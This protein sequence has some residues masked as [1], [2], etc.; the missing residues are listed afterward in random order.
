ME[1][2]AAP[3]PDVRPLITVAVLLVA[4]GL[5]W[6]MR[7]AFSASLWP[8]SAAALLACGLLL[9]HAILAVAALLAPSRWVAVVTTVLLAGELGVALALPATAAWWVAVM[10]TGLAAAML[11]ARGAMT[12]MAS[13]TRTDRV[14]PVATALVVALAL[15][16]ALVGALGYE[17]V[18]TAGWVLAAASL[19]LAWAYMRAFVAALWAIR[20]VM[21]I[22]VIAALMGAPAAAVLGFVLAGAI[23]TVLAWARQAM[24]AAN[25][26]A[27][28]RVS[29]VPVLPE[30]VPAE[31]LESAGFDAR[32]RPKEKGPQ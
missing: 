9:A 32:G 7:L 3:R 21:P 20:T 4:G 1:P 22:M 2:P 29:P 16:P 10:T 26:L 6:V 19:I 31:L 24:A 14:A 13:S 11:W 27:P 5:A 30:M 18:T 12:T 25:P 15:M 23:I 28:E 17:G 8:D